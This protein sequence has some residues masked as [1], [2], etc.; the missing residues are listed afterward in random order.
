MREGLISNLRLELDRLNAQTT[1]RMW[2][3]VNEAALR[4][5]GEGKS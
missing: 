3:R 5:V 2:R 1:F 4:T